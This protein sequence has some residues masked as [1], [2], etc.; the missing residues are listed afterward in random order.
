M[1][2]NQYVLEVYLLGVILWT[3]YVG[4]TVKLNDMEVYL[5]CRPYSWCDGDLK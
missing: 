2:V 5:I 4:L 3:V 1:R